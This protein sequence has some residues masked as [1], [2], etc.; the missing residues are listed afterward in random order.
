MPLLLSGH[1]SFWLMAKA[2]G[3]LLPFAFVY[4]LPMG[5]IT[6]TLLVFGRFSADQELTAARAS[7]LSLIALITPVLL[8]SVGVSIL[9]GIFNLEIAPRS[10]VAYKA[11][12]VNL[13]IEQTAAFLPEDRFVNFPGFVIYARKRNQN[14]LHDVRYYKMVNGHQEESTTASGGLLVVNREKRTLYMVLTNATT[15]YRVKDEP[16]PPSPTAGTNEPVVSESKSGLL[17]WQQ[18]F[19]PEYTTD[20]IN[21]AQVDTEIRKP[22]LSDMCIHQL[23]AEIREREAQG[24]DTT[25]AQVRLHR[26]VAF[27]FA[28]IGFTLIGIPLGVRAHRRET[29]AG[30]ALALVLVLIYYSFIILAQSW[31]TRSELA[32]HLIVWLPN[33]LFQAV[34]AVLLWRANRGV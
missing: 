28:S 14:Q 27:S 31:E 13:G 26:Q 20:E 32:P 4:A 8:L 10:R 30:V 22:R 6:A 1:V 15:I 16:A 25:P 17:E 9:C 11:L 18:L 7:G 33:F 23:R 12:L 21:F 2:I 34:G 29:T 3:L 24:I 5:F 19:F